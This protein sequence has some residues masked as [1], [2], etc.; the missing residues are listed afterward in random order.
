MTLVRNELDALTIA[1][2]V[3]QLKSLGAM[4]V[5]SRLLPDAIKTPEM[6]VGIVLKGRELGTPP[7]VSLSH[8]HMV[9]GKPT[10]SAELMMSMALQASHDVWLAE[11]T[12]ER[13]TVKGVR[14]GSSR[15]QSLTFTMDE[16][17]QAGVTGK[18]VWRQYPAAML[19][20]RAISAFMR[21]AMPDVLMGASYTAEELGA[22]VDGDGEVI[23]AE[24]VE[25]ERPA[26]ALEPKLSSPSPPPP[27]KGSN[28]QAEAK[29]D[30]LPTERLEAFTESLD[31][32]GLTQHEQFRIAEFVLGRKIVSFEGISYADAVAIYNEA[33]HHQKDDAPP[34]D[35]DPEDGFNPNGPGSRLLSKAEAANL[36]RALG[37]FGIKDHYTFAS[38]VMGHKVSSLQASTVA[39]SIKIYEAAVRK[40][41]SPEMIAEFDARQAA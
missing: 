1:A 19:R 29:H 5:A 32:L 27:V 18:Q 40:H 6:A 20:A 8:I 11:S 26:K 30:T 10:L 13:A 2:Q 3:E 28:S 7:M 41:G 22:N 21:M 37:S 35:P 38:E 25:P 36:H 4:L 33:K 12:A 16:A 23:Q 14:K 15:E 31:K 9:N 17:K 24:M 34:F 39:T